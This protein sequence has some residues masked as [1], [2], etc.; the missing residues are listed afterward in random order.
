MNS[1]SSPK[2]VRSPEEQAVIDDFIKQM[3]AADKGSKQAAAAGLEALPRL[4]K[5]C[6][7]ETGSQAGIVMGWLASRYNGSEAL[8]VRLDDI[9]GLDWS[10]AK[11]LVAVILGCG[12]TG[13]ASVTPSRVPASSWRPAPNRRSKH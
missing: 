12:R 5:A 7:R 1:N 6:Y 8:P 13:F 10:L 4:A 9:N 3:H 11:D 2:P